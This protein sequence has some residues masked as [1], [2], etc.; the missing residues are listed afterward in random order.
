LF[1]LLESGEIGSGTETGDD[2]GTRKSV[3]AAAV[4]PKVPARERETAILVAKG[5]Q[6]VSGS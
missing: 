3:D 2:G 1:V 6:E 4:F 5:E